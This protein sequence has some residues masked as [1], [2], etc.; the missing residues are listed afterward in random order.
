MTQEPWESKW[1]RRISVPKPPEFLR[2]LVFHGPNGEK[3]TWQ[4]E[5]DPGGS[6]GTYKEVQQ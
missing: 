1:V 3:E 5:Q 6:E 2:R 4:W